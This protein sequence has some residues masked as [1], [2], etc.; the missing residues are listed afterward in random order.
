MIRYQALQA[1]AP[2]LL[3]A[4]GTSIICL[5]DG[6]AAISD[7]NQLE[8]AMKGRGEACCLPAA[9]QNVVAGLELV[10]MVRVALALQLQ[11]SESVLLLPLADIDVGSS[12]EALTLLC[13]SRNMGLGREDAVDELGHL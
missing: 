1:H 3:R 4:M 12:V 10:G 11:E 13:H 2:L 7:A 5:D 6:I 8:G 9:D